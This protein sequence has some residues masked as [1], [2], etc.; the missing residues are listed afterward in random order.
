MTVQ[1]SKS[2]GSALGVR[3]GPRPPPDTVSGGILVTLSF[4]LLVAFKPNSRL[5]WACT[6]CLLWGQ[7]GS[8]T[9]EVAETSSWAL[10]LKATFWGW[11]CMVSRRHTA[12]VIMPKV[13]EQR[14]TPLSLILMPG[15]P[16]GVP[17]DPVWCLAMSPCRGQHV[18]VWLPFESVHEARAS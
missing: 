14:K 5:G 10:N 16:L 1:V 8:R 18:A 11:W 17:W 2:P 12:Q 7:K 4:W 3:Q 15:M 9:R 6:I 13:R